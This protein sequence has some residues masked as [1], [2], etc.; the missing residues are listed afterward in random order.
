MLQNVALGKPASQSSQYSS[1]A[2]S[3]AVDGNAE[4]NNPRT[5][6]CSHTLKQPLNWLRVDL[7][8]RFKV[9]SVKVTNRREWTG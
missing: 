5:G 9:H 7:E 3:R 4:D 2:A 8:N 1:M 6:S